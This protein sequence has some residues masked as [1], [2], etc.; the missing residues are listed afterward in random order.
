MNNLG[1]LPNAKI[2]KTKSDRHLRLVIGTYG[3]SVKNDRGEMLIDFCAES[4]LSI[5]NSYFQHQARG[6]YIWRS[7]NGHTGLTTYWS[8]EIWKKFHYYKTYESLACG[9]A[10]TWAGPKGKYYQSKIRSNPVFKFRTEETFNKI[11][12]DSVEQ[13]DANEF[14]IERKFY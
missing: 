1:D 8:R 11:T 3:M 13:K 4:D 7:P 10:Q 5:V 6:R 2:G 12:Q 9:S 14:W